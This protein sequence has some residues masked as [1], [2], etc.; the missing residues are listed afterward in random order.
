MRRI[1]FA[2]LIGMTFC[3]PASATESPIEWQVAVPYSLLDE[4]DRLSE[5]DRVDVRWQQIAPT[6]GESMTDWVNRLTLDFSETSPFDLFGS[7]NATV[8]PWIESEARYDRK[9]VFPEST[10]IRVRS[11]DDLQGRCSWRIERGNQAA[12]EAPCTESVVLDRVLLG[13]NVIVRR[14]IDSGVEHRE[15]ILIETRRILALG[16]SYAS[17]EGNPDAPTRWAQTS[18]EDTGLKWLDDKKL[19]SADARWWDNDC[20]RSFWSNQNLAAMWVASRHPKT[21]WVFMQYSCSGAEILDGM[22]VAQSSPPGESKGDIGRSQLAQAAADLCVSNQL[23]PIAPD[24]EFR[25]TV[26]DVVNRKNHKLFFA[27][28]L[29]RKGLDLQ[30]CRNSG[31]TIPDLVLLSIGGNDIGFAALAVHAIGPSKFQFGL[32]QAFAQNSHE[33]C[34]EGA[35]YGC[36]P[37]DVTTIG[38]LPRRYGLLKEAM[39]WSFG[40]RQSPMIQVNYPDPLKTRDGTFCGDEPGT[41]LDGPWTAAARLVPFRF[42]GKWHYNILEGEARLLSN[43]AIRRLNAS[44]ASSKPGARLVDVADAFHGHSWCDSRSSEDLQPLSLPSFAPKDVRWSCSMDNKEQNASPACF[45]PYAPTQRFIRTLNDS[46]LTLSREGESGISGAMHPNVFGHAAIAER[47][48]HEIEVTLR[49]AD[50]SMH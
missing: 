5:A 27:Q 39:T 2:A 41:N 3:C 43:G 37:T 6:T 18:V 47:L 4:A 44:V 45:R 10:R 21:H 36:T 40:A 15:P 23:D 14:S 29:R 9:Y 16:D 17:G 30:R 31:G 24:D 12:V 32:L 46:I 38:Q 13:T 33:V 50:D 25:K 34:P 19:R 11:I 48:A 7:F 8:D 1:I 49:V 35:R 28:T 26:H 20:H 22:M 42:G